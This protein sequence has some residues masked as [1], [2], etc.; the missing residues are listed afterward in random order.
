MIGLIFGETN[1]PIKILE[2]IKKRS[3]KYLIIDLTYAGK[4]RKDRN[5]HSV[6]IGQVGKIINI[7]KKNKCRKVLFAGKV[8]KPKFSKLKLD[9][10]GIYYLP[11]II[12]TSKLGDAAILKEIIKILKQEKINTISSLTFNPELTLKKGNYSKANPNKEDKIDIKKAIATLNRLRKYNFS[13]GVVVR[14]RKVVAIEGKGGT[15]KMLK[16]CKSKK[17][18]GKGVLVKFPKKKQDLRIDLP[19]IGLK[20]FTQCKS[21]G[22]KGIVLKSRQNVFLEQK[23]CISF[24][25]K[26]KIFITIK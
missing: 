3:L 9:F 12:K 24:A 7:L 22:L 26:N 11:R 1:F 4:F 25:N 15:Q 23:K 6:S 5:S 10:K 17:F 21:V 8:K 16:R 20:T 19:T 14:N 2:K 13:Q 18:R